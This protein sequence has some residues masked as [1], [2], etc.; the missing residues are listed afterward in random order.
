MRTTFSKITFT[1]LCISILLLSSSCENDNNEPAA[2]LQAVLVENVPANPTADPDG[3]AIAPTNKFTL[4]SLRENKV[5]SNSDSATAL[6]D[7]GFRSTTIIINGGTSGP[8]EGAAQIV[9][10]IFDELN[11]APVDGY[12]MDEQGAF[13]IPTG[14]GN[15]WYTYTGMDGTPKNT[16]MPIAGKVIALK[17]GDGKYAKVEI[18][19]FY[20]GNPVMDATFDNSKPSRY[21]TFRFIHQPDGSGNLK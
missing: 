8:G 14:S 16:I 10:G 17:T 12:N 13:A 3:Q 2:P 21:Y 11:A 1:V 18:L 6:W 9:N 15:G 5:I 4:Y 20:Y 7:I 19:N